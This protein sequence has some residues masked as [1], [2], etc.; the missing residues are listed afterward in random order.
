[1]D[2][3]AAHGAVSE[4]WSR[5]HADELVQ[6]TFPSVASA[7]G[8]ARRFWAQRFPGAEIAS[9]VQCQPRSDGWHR[10]EC[11]M[12]APHGRADV[13]VR[14]YAK[15]GARCARALRAAYDDGGYDDLSTER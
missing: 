8:A 2:L 4:L 1:M 12:L 14:E 9:P 6:R 13:V 3:R 10:G 11:G 15:L 5:A 7:V